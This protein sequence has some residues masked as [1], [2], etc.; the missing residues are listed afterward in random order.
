M[1]SI[2]AVEAPQRDH[3]EGKATE[4]GQSLGVV[5][6]EVMGSMAALKTAPKRE[7]N[8]AK[9]KATERTRQPVAEIVRLYTKEGNRYELQLESEDFN[10][11]MKQAEKWHEQGTDILVNDKDNPL[12]V[13]AK[14][15]I[16]K[17]VTVGREISP[18]ENKGVYVRGKGEILLDS[19]YGALPLDTSAFD[20][21]AASQG[22][23]DFGNKASQELATVA[24]P[25]GVVFP[26]RSQSDMS[27]YGTEAGQRVQT[28]LEQE[29]QG[30]KAVSIVGEKRPDL[31]K[32]PVPEDRTANAAEPQPDRKVILKKS[33]YELP[34][35][36]RDAYKVK[37]GR[38]YDKKSD[39]VRFEDHGKK[40]ST[41]MEDH[42]VV[43]HMLD[44]A[45]AK[46]WDHIELSG[47]DGFKQMAWL[48]ASAR[49]IK[50]QGYEPSEQDQQKLEQ[51]RH[52]R[53]AS[54]ERGAAQDNSVEAVGS[55]VTELEKGLAAANA[56][57]Q[58]VRDD[59]GS[60]DDD[61]MWA[62]EDRKTAEFDL[63]AHAP[64]G[65]V[66][67]RLVQHG[68]AK[69]KND[70]D[71]KPSYYVT[72]QTRD[73]DERTVWGKDLKRAMSV[74][75]CKV[76]DAIS[77]ERTGTEPVQVQANVRDDATGK[78]VGTQQINARRNEWE[79]KAEPGL[80]LTRQLEPSEQV[81]VDAAVR[82]LQKELQQYPEQ[83]RQEILGKFSNAV[84]K[85]EVQLPIP[86]VAERSA[87]A[88][89][90]PQ[91]E[92]DRGR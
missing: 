12:L 79:V 26:A 1:N 10:G 81:R 66:I 78:V 21:H 40:L 77:L 33:G 2:Q 49:G 35:H 58:Q 82:V 53:G 55:R 25:E 22:T 84:D 68:E 20:R 63:M 47:T 51:L 19:F 65:K 34:D 16:H 45:A 29:Q 87:K 75:H 56:K 37:S 69:Y 50:T 6:G 27:D 86:Q 36:V 71:E 30:A 5:L 44:V 88:M 13:H 74:T 39:Q 67:G 91:P 59:P 14:S 3:A 54:V 61:K 17:N 11:I 43:E 31:A 42:S 18:T 38:F 8:Q 52:E 90:T 73:G 70:H 80:L 57:E 60:T 9:T 92:M 41:S 48:A 85:G 83:L 7:R 72:V 4:R 62:K 64:E 24:A 28:E 15:N 89:P 23:V 32:Q 46:N 76:G